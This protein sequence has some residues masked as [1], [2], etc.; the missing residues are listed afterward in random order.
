MRI[1][2]TLSFL[3]MVIFQLLFSTAGKG[4]GIF[5]PFSYHNLKKSNQAYFAIKGR[6]INSADKK[7]LANASVFLSNTTIG[8]KTG[9][10]GGFTFQKVSPGKYTL[11]I[12]IIG[13][14]TYTESVTVDKS[15]VNLPDIQLTPKTII[16]N[17]VKI[18]AKTDAERE[19]YYEWFKDEFSGRSD[20]AEDCKILNPEIID[21][22]YDKKN[23]TLTASADGFLQIEN[24]A[25]GYKI[26]YL[27]T[28]FTLTN[29]QAN[30]EKVHYEGSAL[31][32]EMKG[33]SAEQRRWKKRREGVYENSPMHFLRSLA[34]DPFNRSTM[35]QF[36]REGFWVLRFARYPNPKR[37]DD[38]LIQ[39]KIN[40]Y[41]NLKSSGTYAKDSLSRWVKIDKLP[42]T[43][44][45]VMPKMLQKEDFVKP[46]D[47]NGVFALGL[48]RNVYSLYINYDKG[49]FSN[50]HD[51]YN[52]DVHGIDNLASFQNTENT[53]VSFNNQYALFD[54]N[55]CA[56]NPNSLVFSGVWGKYRIAE[57]LPVDYDA[58]T[59]TNSRFDDGDLNDSVPALKVP[60]NDDLVKLKDLSDN[61]TLKF[62]IEKL[63]LQF[64]KPYYALGDTIWLKAYL[65]N[66]YLTA[67]DKSSTMYIDIANDSNKVVKQYKLPVAEG[68][69]WGNITLG[70]KDFSAGT[71]TLRAYTNWMRNFGT[72]Y[73]FSK[74]FYVA[75]NGENGWLVN[76]QL[77]ELTGSGDTTNIK[78][79][80]SDI[81]KAPA[82]NK[83]LQLQAMVGNKRVYKQ[84]MQTDNNGLLNINL[85]APEKLANL[86]IIAESVP[87]GKKAVIPINLNRAKNTDIQ[88]LPEGGSLVAGFPAH[89]AFKAI[90]EDG[91]GIDVSGIVIGRNQQQVAEFKSLHLGMGSFDLSVQNGESYTAKVTLPGGVTK[92]YQLPAI[93]AT[94]VVLKVEN[95]ME[96]DSLTIAVAATADIARLESNY[97]LIGKA[98][99]VICYAAVFNFHNGALVK[100]KIAKSLFPS[101]ITH[102]TVMTANKQPLN[103]RLVY[104]DHNDNLNLQIK[105][106]HSSYHSRDSVA[107][108]IKVTDK[109]G[110]PVEGSFSL[111][112]TDDAQVNKDVLNDGNIVTRMLLTSDLKGY[113]EEPGYYLSSKTTEARQA[114][115]NLLLTQGW[116]GCNWEQVFNPPVINYQ[117]EHDFAVTGRVVNVFNKPVKGTDVLLFSKTP[118]ILMDTV[119]DKEGRFVFENFP[120]I[121]TPVFIVKAVNKH[122][123]SFNV[124]VSVDEAKPP[125]FTGTNAPLMA[126]WYINSDTTLLN[127]TKTDALLQQDYLPAGGHR[128]KEV[129][130]SAKKIIKDSQNLNGP[131]NA[132]IVLDEN[133]LEKA[134]KKTWLQLLQENIKGF[135]VAYQSRTV[136]TTVY[137]GNVPITIATNYKSF[138]WYYINFRFARIII[139]GIELTPSLLSTLA[140]VSTDRIINL[141]Y[142]LN[143]H[144][145]EDI[146]GIEVNYSSKYNDRYGLRFQG[147]DDAFIEITTRSGGGPFLGTNTP[148]LYLYKPLAISV[149]AQ[150]YKPRYSVTDTTNHK[151][152]LRSTID[153]EPNIKTGINGEAKVFFYTAD[154]P[155]TYTVTIEGADMNGSLAEKKSKI[156]VK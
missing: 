155:S 56:F 146:K 141:N 18:V 102:F 41:K 91:K 40:F 48:T 62:G 29:Q 39:A 144:D 27:L 46:T 137:S 90:G 84:T 120:R 115:D 110:R 107:L 129:K 126:P 83:T 149:P 49:R 77:K 65:L 134:G 26:K 76:K 143:A 57:L 53:L 47:Q 111:A 81:N 34:A 136:N 125:E 19:Q 1:P 116:V 96:T 11:V 145:A 139:D 153:W 75:G 151:T 93:K 114:L 25:L 78:L 4:H 123:N 87:A 30:A 122:G 31:F 124:S 6:A 17:E 86:T 148:G 112:V 152:D 100:R 118:A 97:F 130:I 113:V 37:P 147:F 131:G 58:G 85:K 103:E 70:Y 142:Y 140:A 50:Y 71:Y 74:S 2:S 117:P 14:E 99:G 33:S 73:F 72:D 16:L 7:V 28:D 66:P 109:T 98:R 21:L 42:K 121:D 101:G 156:T 64:D 3:L 67:S 20:L 132:D 127:Y 105:T 150:F 104:I 36:F 68:L 82:A 154:K 128:L 5:T 24:D 8:A 63:Y 55:G 35:P 135:R 138:G 108:R 32:E 23:S 54:G 59:G 38:S 60:L 80:L 119:T 12:S 9:N 51:G 94:G 88:F 43:I 22:D 95:P 92:E 13:F 15:N 79:Q 44:D 45:T 61:S 133:D 89:I 106:N 10:D 52:L 69:S